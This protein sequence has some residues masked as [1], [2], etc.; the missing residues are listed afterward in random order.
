MAACRAE[1]DA[2]GATSAD[3]AEVRALLGRIKAVQKERRKIP[4]VDPMDPNFR[5]L[6]YCRYADDFLVGVIGSKADAV[7]I[8]ADIQHFLADRLNLRSEEHT[9]E[10]QSLMRNSYAVFC[11]KNKIQTDDHKNHN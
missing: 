11:L 2:I 9:S 1:I 6:R 3:K 5:R 7:R 8:M 10:L 4:S